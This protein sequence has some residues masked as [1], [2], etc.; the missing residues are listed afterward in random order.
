[1]CGSPRA[2]RLV[3]FRSWR[4]SAEFQSGSAFRSLSHRR[5]CG[6]GRR[7]QQQTAR[8]RTPPSF[9]F[10]TPGP[11]PSPSLLSSEDRSTISLRRALSLPTHR[12]PF[13]SSRGLF[14]TPPLAAALS[15]SGSQSPFRNSRGGFA[16][17]HPPRRRLRRR[18]VH[19]SDRS[20][21]RRIAEPIDQ[22]HPHERVVTMQ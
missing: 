12:Y 1:M 15:P 7:T 21:D 20:V 17:P 4:F 18:R 13:R 9:I 11:A 5:S 19:Q 10:R 16:P 3:L 14:G 22:S 8:K 6:R 2:A